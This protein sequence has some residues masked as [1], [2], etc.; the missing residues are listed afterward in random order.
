MPVIEGELGELT[1]EEAEAREQGVKNPKEE[2]REGVVAEE[3]IV[4]DIAGRS[5]PKTKH[6][7][8]P[9]PVS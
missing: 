6:R 4:I 9:K 1:P 3:T 7:P 5:P 2:A 8:K